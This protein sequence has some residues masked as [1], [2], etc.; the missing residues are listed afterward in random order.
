MP[1]TRTLPSR[2]PRALAWS[3]SCLWAVGPS[4]TV[5]QSK[6]FLS[7]AHTTTGLLGVSLP[8]I[9]VS[10]DDRVI[11]VTNQLAEFPYQQ[12]HNAGTPLGVGWTQSSIA[13]GNRTNSYSAYLHPFLSR[14]NLTVLGGAHVTRVLQTGTQSGVPVFRGVEFATSSTGTTVRSH[15]PS[16][17]D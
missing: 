9:S 10:Y 3:V 13:Q 2:L 17:G 16:V 1:C 5:E 8:S 6:E 11:A 7:S 15:V 14:P 4:L 12:D